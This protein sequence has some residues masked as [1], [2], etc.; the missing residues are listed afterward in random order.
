MLKTLMPFDSVH[1]L[2]QLFQK[3]GPMFCNRLFSVA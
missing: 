2:A 1:V 3:A